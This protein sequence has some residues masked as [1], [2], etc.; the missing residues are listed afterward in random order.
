ML[1]NVNWIRG[2]AAAMIVFI[3]MADDFDYQLN[4]SQRLLLDLLVKSSTCIFVAISGFF[5]QL[6]S[7]KYRYGS[8]LAKKLNNVIIPYVL[9]SLPAVALF[10]L[11]LKTEHVW[12]DIQT[13][14]TWPMLAQF[15]F[16]LATGAHLGPLWFIPALALIYL[17]APLLYWL[18]RRRGFPLI[19]LLGIYLFVATDRP[20]NNA[21]PVMAAV[22]FIPIYLLGMLFCQYRTAI[23]QRTRLYAWIFALLL[24]ALSL[25]AAYDKSYFGLQK[26]CVFA[27]L[28]LVLLRQQEWFYRNPWLA[29]TLS[30]VGVYSFTLYFL[31]GYFAGR[32]RMFGEYL[33]PDTF[34]LYLLQRL[35]LTLATIAICIG[36]T[37]CVKRVAKQHSRLLIGS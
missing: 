5:F 1:D 11:K 25:M 20:E 12:I 7:G 4:D 14:Y 22:H 2:I 26:F 31:H 21:N 3:H 33:Q 37:Y 10:L 16:L 17:C 24:L 8:Y 9:I 27:L 23:Q 35:L 28:Y 30:L 13:F 18:S 6:N 19:A 36:I 34:P 29:D 32:Y 15:V